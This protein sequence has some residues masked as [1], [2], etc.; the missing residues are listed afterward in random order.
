MSAMHK[1]WAIVEEKLG[2]TEDHSRAHAPTAEAG[3]E[4][5]AGV[6]AAGDNI[7]FRGQPDRHS[8]THE[9]THTTQRGQRG[10]PMLMSIRVEPDNA[11]L[12][13]GAKQQYRATGTYSD[14]STR[15][16]TATVR[17]WCSEPDI[18]GIDERGLAI[19]TGRGDAQ[20]SATDGDTGITGS[21]K[22]AVTAPRGKAAGS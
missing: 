7:A 3:A 22:V 13:A 20:I 21:T 8:I 10:A 5:G 12:A 4:L 19:G 15:D 14:G 6:H 1:L 11:T 17:W 16:L 2:R 9:T 18:I